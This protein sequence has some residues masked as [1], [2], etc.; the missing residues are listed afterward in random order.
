MKVC[1]Q[2]MNVRNKRVIL[3]VDYNVP[4]LNDKILDD[5]KIKETLETIFYL[6]NEN[7]QIVILSHFGKIRNELDKKKYSL[8]IVAK[9]LQEL[10][11]QEVYFSKINFGPEVLE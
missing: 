11:H 6:L 1:L 5:S 2:N 4:V 3:R 10:I 7:C 8:E 9:R